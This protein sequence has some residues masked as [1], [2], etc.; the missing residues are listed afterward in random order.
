MPTRSLTLSVPLHTQRRSIPFFLQHFLIEPVLLAPLSLVSRGF[1]LSEG[2]IVSLSEV[3]R[4]LSIGLLWSEQRNF[5]TLLFYRREIS[6]FTSDLDNC[7]AWKKEVDFLDCGIV[8]S[9]IITRLNR[10]SRMK[11]LGAIISTTAALS[12]AGVMGASIERRSLPAVTVGG[13]G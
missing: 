1:T 8:L 10:R 12:A 5:L 11:G 6:Q 4:S 2:L 3:S 9:S 13:N 7:V